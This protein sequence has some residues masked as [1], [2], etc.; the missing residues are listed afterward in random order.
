MKLE[1]E[2]KTYIAIEM[3]NGTGYSDSNANIVS[4]EDGVDLLTIM[5]KEARACMGVGGKILE[6]HMF[7][8]RFTCKYETIDE[9][10]GVIVY[11]QYNGEVGIELK[12]DTL[13][14]VLCDGQYYNNC[15]NQL[16]KHIDH[17]DRHDEFLE[18]FQDRQ[19]GVHMDDEYHKYVLLGAHHYMEYKYTL[20]LPGSDVYVNKYT[21]EE[22]YIPTE[23]TR[24]F[25]YFTVK[26]D[27]EG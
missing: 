10:C 3:F 17:E 8:D 1:T 5:K 26:D 27:N 12:P 9:D 15:I 19:G 13:S 11:H 21:G 6:I 23:I 20:D 2:T 22:Y 24:N 7:E 18:V 4:F 25:T 14:Y 16:E